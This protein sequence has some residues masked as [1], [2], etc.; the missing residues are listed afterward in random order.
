MDI[1]EI[2]MQKRILREL[3]IGFESIIGAFYLFYMMKFFTDAIQRKKKGEPIGFPLAWSLF[4]LGQFLFD[5]LK[6]F[7]DFYQDLIPELIDRAYLNNVANVLGLLGLIYISIQIEHILKSGFV[8]TI[9]IGVISLCAV[10]FYNFPSSYLTLFIF[11]AFLSSL[12]IIFAAVQSRV[13]HHPRLTRM[14]LIFIISFILMFTG[15]MLRADFVLN[16]FS[17]SFISIF[18]DVNDI[19]YIR[20]LAGDAIVIASIFIMQFSFQEFP[21]I[22][23]L[24]WSNYLFELHIASYNGIELFN[25]RFYEERGLKSGTHPDLM[26]AAFSGIQDIIKEITGS[27]ENVDLIDQGN[28]KMIFEKTKHVIVILIVSEYL[29]IYRYKLKKLI[30]KVEEKY[31]K[32]IAKWTGDMSMFQDADELI[33]EYFN[34]EDIP[35]PVI[36]IDRKPFFSFLRRDK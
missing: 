30:P 35:P 17:E 16:L 36:K 8:N 19:L 27:E 9:I 31:G 6:M 13:E 14:L 28:F 24:N 11:V 20:L 29:E 21:S 18:G 1:D 22:M 34:I 12:G 26:A 32:Y 25:K 7:A 2:L 4:F 33:D 3:L 10:F 5:A 15:N 23:E